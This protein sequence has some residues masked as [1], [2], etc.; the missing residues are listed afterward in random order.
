MTASFPSVAIPATASTKGIVKIV[1]TPADAANPTSPVITGAP[2]D[3]GK[4]FDASTG[5]P[6]AAGGGG[7]SPF[8][9]QAGRYYSHQFQGA[10]YG[11]A[12][13]TDGTLAVMP[14]FVGETRTFDRIGIYVTAGGSAGAQV[15]FAVYGNGADN[16]PGAL[17]LD[18]G[19]LAATAEAYLEATISQAL[20]A[21]LYW[22]GAVG[23]AA[24]VTSASTRVLYGNAASNL[25]MGS[26]N[27]A[28]PNGDLGFTQT[29]VTGALPAPFGTPAGR[30][31][32]PPFVFVRAV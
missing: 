9:F 28:G 24:P 32:N 30:L 26:A 23:Q 31:N 15:R 14:F 29:G 13:L 1:G 19:A 21:G 7:F 3:V 18:S 16:Q 6:I 20:D 4:T 11:S 12:A 27:V 2:G 10:G 25:V 22:I 17:V 8:K 5:L